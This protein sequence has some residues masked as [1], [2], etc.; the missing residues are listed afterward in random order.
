MNIILF[1]FLFNIFNMTSRFFYFF[2]C[3]RKLLYNLFLL[4]LLYNFCIDFNF[5]YEVFVFFFFSFHFISYIPTLSLPTCSIYF[6]F[7]HPISPSQ[8][9]TPPRLHHFSH[10]GY[11]S[12]PLIILVIF[13]CCDV[14]SWRNATVLSAFLSRFNTWMGHFY[15]GYPLR[16]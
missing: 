14:N 16:C 1:L 10:Q 11:H 12:I 9:G 7:L 8:G 6:V 5:F 13:P 2:I 15:S 4:F 3:Y